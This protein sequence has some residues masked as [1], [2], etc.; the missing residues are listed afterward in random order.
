MRLG[1]LRPRP[2]LR[3]EPGLRGYRA[4]IAVIVV[5]AL[6]VLGAVT[7]AFHRVLCLADSSACD[8]AAPVTAPTGAVELPAASDER[9]VVAAAGTGTL[10]GGSRPAVV[11]RSA[12][13]GAQTVPSWG[14]LW[15]D[16]Q[17]ED[18]AAG[19][20]GFGGE[21]VLVPLEELSCGSPGTPP[22]DAW[23]ALASDAS[24]SRAVGLLRAPLLG[25]DTA[26]PAGAAP[27]VVDLA[28]P[29]RDD[30]ALDAAGTVLHR[31]VLAPDTGATTLSWTWQRR[32]GALVQV[33]AERQPDG[34]LSTLT[35]SALVQAPAPDGAPGGLERTELVIPVT[36]ASSAALDSW[37]VDLAAQRVDPEP[38]DLTDVDPADL[39]ANAFERLAALTGEGLRESVVLPDGAEPTAEWLRDAPLL[40]GAQRTPVAERTGGGQWEAVS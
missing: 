8:T 37:L 32:D 1:A 5:I 3:A 25:L 4:M 40:E 12:V 11:D 16:G 34:A 10:T 24:A 28:L 29:V 27:V 38:S 39:S 21:G 31:S 19:P 13:P 30:A 17:D 26:D 20:V 7:G 14:D 18:E 33:V 6:V 35:V 15:S 22:C 9:A 36:P 2:A 23:E